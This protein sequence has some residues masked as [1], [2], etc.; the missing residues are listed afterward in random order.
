MYDKCGIVKLWE[1]GRA[2]PRQQNLRGCQWEP[3][4]G[5]HVSVL[6]SRTLEFPASFFLGQSCSMNKGDC[7]HG[8]CPGEPK[9]KTPNVIFSSRCKQ[10]VKV[11]VLTACLLTEKNN[12]N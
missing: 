6:F 3:G 4:L 7:Y 1:A 10:D 8:L 9:T 12:F 11:I 5:P 2:T